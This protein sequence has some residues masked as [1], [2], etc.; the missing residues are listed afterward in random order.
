MTT[1]YVFGAGASL[2]AKYPL[3]AGMGQGLLEFMLK[4]PIDRYR[5][6][7][8][9][10]IELF[11]KRPNVE[12]MITALEERIE[13]LKDGDSHERATRSVLAHAHAHVAE[14]L[15]EWFRGT[16]DNPAPLYAT[17]AKEVIKP[18]DT[19]ITF[20]YD[21]SLERELKR[22]GVWDLSRGYGFPLGDAD[23]RSDVLLLKLH[24]SINWLI[25]L[26]GGV[27]SGPVF[28]G[29]HGSTGGSPVIHPVDA[30]YLGYTDF[31]G[32]TYTGG[33][34]M[35]S[36][37]LP[38]RSKQFFID[39]SLGREFEG[40]WNSLWHHAA[41]AMTK[42]DRIV[43]CGYSMPP[44]DE[45]ARELLLDKPNKD[46]AITVVCGPQSQTIADEFKSARFVRVEA[47][48]GGYFE[49]WLNSDTALGATGC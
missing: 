44:A 42:S 1:T 38:G 10:L 21:D 46:A 24:G 47:F 13:A 15:R 5:D 2:H 43:I 22:T 48:A 16:H 40:F 11:G 31:S 7:A 8:N 35:L 34:T 36:M 30:N 37:I 19:V 28:G 25:S 6:S 18:G 26:F 33:G 32:R 23:T 12:D 41:N 39:T 20:N 17:F 14:M 29:P 3:C 45:R 27:T 4:Y 49:Q 9:V